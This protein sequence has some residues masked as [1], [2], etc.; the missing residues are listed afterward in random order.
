MQCG[1]EKENCKNEKLKKKINNLFS[2]KRKNLEWNEKA[3][4][5]ISLI[6]KRG[7]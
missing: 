6:A 2:E 5:L 7:K 3:I 1:D 4:S